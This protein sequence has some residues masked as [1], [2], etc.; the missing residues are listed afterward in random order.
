MLQVKGADGSK[1]TGEFQ[2]IAH[3]YTLHSGAVFFSLYMKKKRLVGGEIYLVSISFKKKKE[4]WSE[5]MFLSSG[6]C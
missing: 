6:I 5:W 2:I 4:V 1:N 3:Y